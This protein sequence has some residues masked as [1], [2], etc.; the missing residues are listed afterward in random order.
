[1]FKNLEDYNMFFKKQILCYIYLK[2]WQEFWLS[3]K[4]LKT[5]DEININKYESI[6][7]W[8]KCKE[9]KAPGLSTQFKN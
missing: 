3:Y 6:R 7:A 2:A 1:M 4:V 9:H 8:A 5:F